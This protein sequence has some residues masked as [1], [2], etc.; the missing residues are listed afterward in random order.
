MEIYFKMKVLD[1]KVTDF[2]KQTLD[3]IPHMVLDAEDILEEQSLN[4]MGMRSKNIEANIDYYNQ[5]MI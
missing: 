1:D 2:L 4:I 5:C 3:S